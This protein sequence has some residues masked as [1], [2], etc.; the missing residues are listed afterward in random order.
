MNARRFGLGLATLS[1]GVAVGLGTPALAQEAPVECAG[2]GVVYPP[3]DCPLPP[4]D[5]EPGLSNT[6]PVTGGTITA[7]SGNDEFDPG[8]TVEVGVQSVYIRIVTTVANAAGAA[9]STFPLP[10]SL[11]PGAHNVVFT[12]LLEG[13]PTTVAL[14]FTL[15]AAA[16]PIAGVPGGGTSTPIAGSFLP[17]TGSVEAIPIAIS[18]VALLLAG[19]G[20]VVVARRRRSELETTSIA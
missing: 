4:E 1:F 14:P 11:P 5:Q 17:R 19:T 15:A 13:Q 16:S 8:S 12:G 9:A 6:T 3:T 2:G 10:A 20:M 18:G 7:V